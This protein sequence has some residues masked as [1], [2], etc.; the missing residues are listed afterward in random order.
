MALNEYAISH[1]EQPEMNKADLITAATPFSET[2]FVSVWCL[3]PRTRCLYFCIVLTK[4]FVLTS[5]SRS[6]SPDKVFTA[7]GVV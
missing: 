2:S 7:P 5:I 1:P 6:H 4:I 3:P